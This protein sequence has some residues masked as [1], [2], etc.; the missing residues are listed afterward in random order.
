VRAVVV[1]RVVVVLALTSV[2]VAVVVVAALAHDLCL[3]LLT[4]HPQ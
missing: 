4:S 2:R 3:R 1:L